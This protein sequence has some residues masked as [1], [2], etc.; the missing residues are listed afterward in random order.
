MVYETTGLTVSRF[1][2]D[3]CLGMEVPRTWNV[4]ENANALDCAD[5]KSCGT[6]G[7]E[8]VLCAISP[9]SIVFG[10]FR[11]FEIDFSLIP[12]VQFGDKFRSS[13][14]GVDDVQVQH[15]QRWEKSVWR[16]D[17]P[18]DPLGPSKA[19]PGGTLW[20]VPLNDSTWL[21]ITK[22]SRGDSNYE[23]EVKRILETLDVR[24][25]PIYRLGL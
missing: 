3:A 8:S 2:K 23:Q 5:T 6:R 16:I 15:E 11:F 12:N 17:Y 1:T 21:E 13:T 24:S 7:A 22:W 25:L 20:Y 4:F 9:N 10:D 18:L 19:A 14:E